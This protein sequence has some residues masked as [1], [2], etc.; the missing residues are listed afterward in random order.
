[1]TVS[2]IPALLLLSYCRSRDEVSEGSWLPPTVDC[3]VQVRIEKISD[4]K[5]K[6][7]HCF[8]II[9]MLQNA[10]NWLPSDVAS[11]PRRAHSWATVHYKPDNSWKQSLWR[12]LELSVS[13]LILLFPVCVVDAWEPL[14]NETCFT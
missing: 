11:Y 8:E 3:A 1:M 4:C 12:Y 14:L 9:T 5:T 2:G 10:G 7:F 13:V 6:D